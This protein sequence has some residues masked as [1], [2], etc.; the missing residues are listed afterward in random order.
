[1]DGP[2]GPPLVPRLLDEARE[3][4]V[5]LDQSPDAQRQRPAGFGIRPVVDAGPFAVLGDALSDVFEFVADGACGRARVGLV[6]AVAQH[7][8]QRATYQ[9][10]LGGVAARE[11]GRGR[12]PDDGADGRVEF[13]RPPPAEKLLVVL[14]D[15]PADQIDGQV[16]A[17]RDGM[18]VS[19]E[20]TQILVQ[21]DVVMDLSDDLVR[22]F[23][24]PLMIP[25]RPQVLEL[26]LG[27]RVV[28]G[29]RGSQLDLRLPVRL[30]RNSMRKTVWRH[31]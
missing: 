16:E 23:A 9:V 19:V 30:I 2:L 22:T 12:H 27:P 1:M 31:L 18:R 25:L 24:P 10:H 14:R 11:S 21:A 3:I 5:A 8:L 6:G 26:V 20:G 4:G 7:V 15:R 17:G 28:I 29:K 13:R